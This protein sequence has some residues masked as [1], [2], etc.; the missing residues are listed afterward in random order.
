[1]I[2]KK[3]WIPLIVIIALLGAGFH[4]RDDI[5]RLI[6]QQTGTT[7]SAQGPGGRPD[8]SNL[9]TTTIRPA[10]ESAQVSASGNIE[11]SSQRP[12]VL[13]VDGMVTEVPVEVGDEVAIDDLL[14]ALNTTDLERAMAQAEL[15]MD[16][17]GCL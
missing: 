15:G 12:V 9:T 16:L 14:V 5:Q 4:F 13:E 8:P 7:A 6:V 3:V 17:W 10:T 11:I 2:S 1:M